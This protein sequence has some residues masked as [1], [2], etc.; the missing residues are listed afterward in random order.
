MISVVKR[1][2]QFSRAENSTQQFVLWVLAD[3]AR[4]D[5]GAE[6]SEAFPSIATLAREMRADRRTVQRAI[7]ALLRIGDLRDDGI[8]PSGTRRY[9]V[10]VEEGEAS[11]CRPLR[12]IA[13]GEGRQ[14]ATE[15][16]AERREGGGV[17]PP[18]PKV[19]GDLTVS[20]PRRIRSGGLM[21]GSLPRDHVGHAWCGDYRRCVPAFLHRDFLGS[22][23]GDV[24]TRDQ[25]LREFYKSTMAGIAPD[26]PVAGD[27]R[28]FWE[29]RIV[30]HFGGAPAPGGGTARPLP[31]ATAWRR[32]CRHVPACRNGFEHELK[33]EAARAT[34]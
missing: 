11:D 3:H 34:A 27:I 26:Q 15:G 12:Q 6:G 8:S 30:A 32:E 10:C 17:A 18:K 16:A 23:G 25:R 7:R 22:I 29:P 28:R 1:V 24:D 2:R 20:P 5:D 21:A 31:D 14:S 9:V 33:A 4:Q 19:N 13:T